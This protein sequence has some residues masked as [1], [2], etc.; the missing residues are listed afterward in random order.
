[1]GAKRAVKGRGLMDSCEAMR[2]IVGRSGMSYRA[3]SE[4]M[5]HYPTWLSST[6]H[7]DVSSKADTLARLCDVCGY[8]LAAMPRADVPEGAIVIDPAE[9]AQG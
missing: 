9:G 2:E 3:V 6:L 1:M 4:A 5:G 7:K 8:S